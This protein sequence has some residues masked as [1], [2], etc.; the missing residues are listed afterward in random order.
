MSAACCD[1]I[2]NPNVYG[3]R[4]PEE[5]CYSHYVHIT[6]MGTENIEAINTKSEK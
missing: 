4:L 2:S 6:H 1:V 3:V 5:Y